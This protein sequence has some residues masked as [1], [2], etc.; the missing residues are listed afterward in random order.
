MP[1]ISNEGSKL[2]YEVHGEGHPVFFIHGGGGNTIAWF[3][4]VPFFSRKY[5]A[6][7]VD[8]RG[9]KNSPCPPELS[10]PRFYRS[11]MLAIME[12]EN[13]AEAAFVCQ[14]LGAWAGL[15]IA[16]KSPERV[17]CLYINGSPT[18]AYSEENWG[19]LRHGS[20]VFMQPSGGRGDGIGW[21]RK[22]IEKNPATH[23]LYQQIKQLNPSPKFDSNKMMDDSIKLH[24]RDFEGYAV[25]TMISGG[26]HD[27]FLI[28][29]S[30]IHTATLIPGCE[31]YTYRDAGH[32]AYFETPDAFNAV[33]D[34]FLA[35]F[36]KPKA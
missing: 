34:Q 8:L 26:D 4:Q 33:V 16:A 35:R 28:P 3:Q 1:T 20:D 27:D 32:S 9:F 12:A 6:I 10:H 23:F 30:H 13:L 17:S 31:T 11:D 7:T 19:V 15:A 25:P 24:P 5:K 21:N 14:S 2:Y 36:V 22:L 18:P 29:G